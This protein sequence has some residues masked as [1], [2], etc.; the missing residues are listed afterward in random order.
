MISLHIMLAPQYVMV[1]VV[2]AVTFPCVG[3]I[4]I[5]PIAGRNVAVPNVVSD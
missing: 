3:F 4:V 2:A 5:H 1:P